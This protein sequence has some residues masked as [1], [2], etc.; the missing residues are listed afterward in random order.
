MK[1][2]EEPWITDDGYRNCRGNT[3]YVP[4]IPGLNIDGGGA[5][6]VKAS[7]DDVEASANGGVTAGMFSQVQSYLVVSDHHWTL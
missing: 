7:A 5:S 6:D 3:T 2:E 4:V 1:F